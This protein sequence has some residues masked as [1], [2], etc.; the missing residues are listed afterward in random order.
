M[1][2]ITEWEFTADVASQINEILKEHVNLPFSEAKCE[3]RKS[4][5]NQRRDITLLNRSGKPV[6][7][8]EVKMPDKRDGRSPF[9][10]AVV[11]DAHNK[12]NSIGVEYF[13][14]WNINDCILWKTFE[15]GKSITERDIEPIK[16]LSPPIIKSD[17]LLNP[18]VKDQIRDFLEKLLERC[19]AIL[20]GEKPLAK[21][22]LDEKFI[23]VW[24]LALMPIVRETLFAVNAKY[25]SDAVFKKHLEKWMREEQGWTISQTDET[26]IRENLESS[27]KFSS[28]VLANKIVFYKALRRQ[29]PKLKKLE[30]SKDIKTGTDLK[31]Y[32]ESAFRHA[33]E[34]T[35]DYETVFQ[36]DFGDGLPLLDDDAVESW[37]ELLEDTNKF[38]FTQISYEV[39]G[40]IFES[41][42]SPEERH[43]FGQH[44]TR[45][46]I[47]DLINAFCIRKADA[48]VLDPSCGGGTF[49][50]RAYQRKKD[51]SGGK[52][53]HQ[54]LIGQIY[55]T[56]IS[57][58]PVHLT[59]INLATRDLKE[60]AN[61]PLVARKDFLK[62]KL[63]A[64]IFNVPNES[65]AN[66]EP[67]PKLDAV[68]GNPP[69]IRQEKITEY[70]GKNYKNLLQETVKKDAPNTELSGRSDILCYFFTHSFALLEDNG[71][72]GL[73]TSS[74]WLDTAYGFD[75]QKFLLE[76]FEIVAIFESNCEPWFTG[77]RVTTAATILRKQPDAEKRNANNVK[78][79][80]LKK[81][82]ADF[83][84]YDKSDEAQRRATF[85][86]I[87]EKIENLAEEEENET[88]R[89][90]VVNQA[91]L[92]QAGCLNFDVQDE[93]DESEEIET[94]AVKPTQ[95]NFI[96]K[97]EQP[98]LQIAAS[99][100]NTKSQDIHSEYKGYK[101]GIFL[102]APEIFNKLLKRGGAS[103]VPLGQIAEI[104]RGITSGCDE[105]FYPYDKTEEKLAENLTD[106]E[107]K[108]RFGISKK[109]TEKI[110]IVQAGDK[111]Q[112][113]IEAEYLEPEV[114]SVMGLDS[115][116]IVPEKLSRK[117][118]LIDIPKDK[119]KDK[120]VL[121]YIN[122]G[123]RQKFS[124]R[125][126]IEAR[127]N[128]N[129]LWYDIT[130]ARRS[131]VLWCKA[132]QYRHIAWLNPHRLIANCRMYDIFTQ[133]DY[134]ERV[135]CAVLNST[136][137]ALAK[138]FF[139]RYVGREGSLDTEV[140]DVRM[141]QIP[142]PKETT[143]EISKKLIAA[144]ELM[145][146]RKTLPLMDV[147]STDEEI[148]TGE[149][150]LAD[151]QVL[152]D[153]VLEL[154]GIA[155]AEE[156]RQLRDELYR[157]ITKLYRQIRIAEKIM[158]KYRSQTARKGKQTAHSIAEE[159]WKEFGTAPPAHFT[160]LDFVPATAETETIDL[161]QGKAKVITHGLY[162]NSEVQIGDNFIPLGNPERSELVKALADLSIHG[163]IEIPAS[164][165]ISEKA[166]KSY[167]RKFTEL[168]KRFHAEAAT[169]TADENLQE[170]IVKELWKKI[171]NN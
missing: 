96:G 104:K 55:G 80:W 29:F 58:Y 164:P 14:T 117:A 134:D 66:L 45:S 136:L 110:R 7:T 138:S 108:D 119:L 156:R 141:M 128:A 160:P 24:E 107:F 37:Q 167:E 101:W 152:D 19:A 76:N 145:R 25:N 102:R 113:L 90:R 116:E 57:A 150:A 157:E 68:I 40:Q 33:T 115:V 166:L 47:V 54:E 139:G 98:S 43:K 162:G 97:P 165:E 70:Y 81:P 82:I 23:K 6:F 27:A 143:S 161:P 151:R 158:Q 64:K 86:N 114:H 16:A 87:R 120:H 78:F 103:F 85:E 129:K 49:L 53:S 46:E 31:E 93:E 69:Y 42:L 60:G 61:Y 168:N 67:L 127:I 48:K 18:R 2:Q 122:Y 11:V 95:T 109:E 36:S 73:L 3:Q 132:H 125:S 149:L 28:Y 8:G 131:N 99:T 1:S 148:W 142:N 9:N 140:I 51:L 74:N 34:I 88:W 41:M 100:P 30:I 171:K 153:A 56:D 22:P 79:V 12:A 105:F 63:N 163:K 94:T 13:F 65:G 137:V 106:K 44:Y 50:V 155:D 5:S 75:L 21:L 146:K 26:T 159:I 39:I 77:A 71:Y 169:F 52:L 121:K 35:Q 15:P 32:L 170:K 59:T 91:E 10:E 4:G 126:T 112:H 144:F 38:D 135:L 92:F 20:S 72:I 111:S 84:S 130:T 124:E 154:I 89:V 118:L 133:K 17:D 123:E 62:T 147:D 83:V